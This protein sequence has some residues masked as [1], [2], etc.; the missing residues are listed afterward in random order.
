VYF[1]SNLMLY[2]LCITDSL[3]K[4]FMYFSNNRKIYILINRIWKITCG[5]HEVT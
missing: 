5:K 4:Y 1:V 3:H 2:Q